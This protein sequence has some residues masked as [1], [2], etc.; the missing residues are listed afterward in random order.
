[1]RTSQT[2]KKNIDIP[3]A[4]NLLN[5]NGRQPLT[6]PRLPKVKN[7]VIDINNINK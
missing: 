1:M 5:L 6:L 3:S 7:L 4:W 2:E